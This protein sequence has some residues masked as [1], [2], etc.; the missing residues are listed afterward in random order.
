MS[1]KMFYAYIKRNFKEN[2]T[3]NNFFKAIDF[4]METVQVACAVIIE[5]R[6]LLVAQ[7]NE[8]MNFPFK[9]EFPGGK[10]NPGE[11]A[12]E[13]LHRELREELNIEVTI[14][15]SLKNSFYTHGNFKINLIP[16]VVKYIDGE[17][18]LAEHHDAKW[19]VKEDMK[20]L[21]WAPA[22]LPIV[23]YILESNY[24]D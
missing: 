11:T 5:N 20:K 23:E 15:A 13:C 4:K 7:R 24:I 9:W 17:L 1:W 19:V 2:K 16:F 22:D 18:I 21:D 12:E 6:K 14:E 10:I 8:K 3:V